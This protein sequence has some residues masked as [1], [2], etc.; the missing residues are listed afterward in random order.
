MEPAQ[1]ASLR[2][3]TLVLVA[4][5]TLVSVVA[6]Y[7][8]LRFV[9]LRSFR[10]LE[11][12]TAFA[13]LDRAENAI[14]N[15]QNQVAA[16]TRDYAAWD[17]TFFWL[18]GEAPQ[19]PS[20]N[21]V[22]ETFEN[23]HVGLVFA[24]DLRGALVYGS[25]WDLEE[26][27][28]MP[29]PDVT[30]I[31]ETLCPRARCRQESGLVE[32]SNGP[33]LAAAHAVERSDGSGPSPGV[34][35]MGRWLT[36]EEVER[37]ALSLEL[38]LELREPPDG[39]ERRVRRLD[40]DR[41]S[42]RGP[43]HD[44]GGHPYLTIEVVMPRD[45]YHRGVDATNAIALA[46][47]L[48]GLVFA[49]AML[50]LVDR[51]VLRRVHR[52]SADVQRVSTDDSLR[53]AVQGNDE[54]AALAI[55]INGML[56]DLAKARAMLRSAFGRYVSEEVAR[57]VLSR[58]EGAELGGQT[59]DVTIL[60]MDLRGYSTITEKM[61]P[62]D[63]VALLNDYF[64]AMSEIVEKHGGVVIEFLGDAILAVFGAPAS[65]DRHA[66]AAVRAALA[67]E[68][69]GEE[70]NLRWRASGRADLWRAHGIEALRSRIG[71]HSGR[72]VV[73]NLG[74]KTR[75][76]YAVIGDT[77]NT[78]ARVQTLNDALG[79][80]VLV[81]SEVEAQLGEELKARLVDRGEHAVKGRERPVHVYT[82]KTTFFTS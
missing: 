80:F 25:A 10:D 52:L 24:I 31:V 78:A 1:P 54:L 55:R 56:G 67:I 71:I 79:T 13:H 69:H 63:V 29:M 36:D 62:A 28:P 34:L 57:E 45:V 39:T 19:Y 18:R 4:A 74:S 15:S 8:P 48:M 14:R 33:M 32:T 82:L 30:P 60:F 61:E 21:F 23:N 49:I 68:E 37:L 42:A 26:G 47:A 16:T 50:L 64:G 66:D 65:L 58:P 3:R 7:V 73:G 2:R 40:D 59:R 17:D 9:L 35:F 72:V 41:V 46:V 5:T 11:R 81:T 12:E 6:L 27:T 70:L 51:V 77:V 75:M 22:E 76:K 43:L 53:V 38:D 20:I 44:R